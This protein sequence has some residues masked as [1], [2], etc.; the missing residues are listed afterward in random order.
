[1]KC[2]KNCGKTT[3]IS[4]RSQG[5]LQFGLFCPT[6]SHI[7]QRQEQ[8]QKSITSEKLEEKKKKKPRLI[9]YQHSNHILKL[10]LLSTA[11]KTKFKTFVN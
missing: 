11:R 1:M 10:I 9:D 7:W 5:C 2:L 8:K 6:N 3:H 4:Q